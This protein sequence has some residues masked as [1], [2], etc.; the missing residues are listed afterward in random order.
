MTQNEQNDV[1][2]K[3]VYLAAKHLASHHL[4]KK[5][6]DKE[7]LNGEDDVSGP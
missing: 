7:P 1:E 6:K 4:K 2:R 5:G 3:C